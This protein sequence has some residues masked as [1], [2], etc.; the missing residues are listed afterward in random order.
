ML[1]GDTTHRSDAPYNHG[2]STGQGIFWRADIS[3]CEALGDRI[4]SYCTAGDPF[5]DVG[6]LVIPLTHR[7]YIE[8]Y[9]E[10]VAAYIIGQF[11]SGDDAAESSSESTPTPVPE[12]SGTET[13]PETAI[14]MAVFL[15]TA[16]VI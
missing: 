3:T 11:E 10:E 12:N 1:F 14:A 4:R 8:D 6:D 16:M 15:F 13:K 9:G 7:T 2:N 5:C